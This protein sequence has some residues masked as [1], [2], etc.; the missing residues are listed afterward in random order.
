[1]VVQKS[2][3][4]PRDRIRQAYYQR[5]RACRLPHLGMRQHYH[6]ELQRSVRFRRHCEVGEW[7]LV[8]GRAPQL[9][10]RARPVDQIEFGNHPRRPLIK[11]AIV[12][13]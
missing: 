10:L 2:V 3:A 12:T 1:M 11:H 8:T 4:S 9:T 7:I 13:P 6:S 5:R